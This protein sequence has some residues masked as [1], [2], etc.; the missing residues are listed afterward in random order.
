MDATGNG[1]Y[2]AEVAGQKYGSDVIEAVKLS[3]SWYLEH[4]PKLK[5]RFQDATLAVPRDADVIADFGDLKLVKGVAKIP[6]TNR[7]TGSDGLGRHGDAAIGSAML[8]YA[9]T[10]DPVAY[11][12]EAAPKST[13][14]QEGA[15]DGRRKFRERAEEDDD[16][17]RGTARGAF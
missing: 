2:L 1:S 17:M 9:A 8:C 16:I 6:A 11:G 7:R 3:D 4:M 15:G 10:R 5:A 12:Y 13:R 14:Y